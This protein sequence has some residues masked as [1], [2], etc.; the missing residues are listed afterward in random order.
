MVKKLYFPL[1]TLL[2]CLC[3]SGCTG[4]PEATVPPSS[5]TAAVSP[6]LPPESEAPTELPTAPLTAP[7][8]A[9]AGTVVCGLDLGGLSRADAVQALTAAADSYTMSL[10]TADTEVNISAADVALSFDEEAFDAFW[11]ALEA[12]EATANSLFS[13]DTDALELLLSAALEH[14]AQEPMVVYSAAREMFVLRPGSAGLNRDISADAAQAAAALQRLEA[15]C[16]LEGDGQS[17]PPSVSDDDPRLT[18]AADEANRILSTRLVYTFSAEQEQPASEAL[19]RGRIADLVSI[20]PDY[21]VSIH[22]DAV[23]RCAAALSAA[24]SDAVRQGDFV[25]SAGKT[26]SLTVDYYGQQVDNAALAEDLYFCLSSGISGT[27]EAPYAPAAESGLPYGGSYVEVD[28]TRQELL[29][30]RDGECVVSTPIVSGCVADGTR[31]PTGVFTIYSM[32]RDTWLSG[33]T[34][35]DHVDYW[36]AFYGAYGLHDASWRSEFGDEI[37]LHEGSHGCPNL[38]V[39]VAGQVYEN[40]GIGTHVIIHGGLTQAVDLTQEITGT[41]SYE[42]YATDEAFPLDYILKY[43]EAAVTFRSDDPEV[44]SVSPEG[45]VTVRG[46]GSAS[47]TIRAEAFTYHTAAELS[48]LVTVSPQCRPEEHRFGDWAVVTEAGCEVSGSESRVCDACGAEEH[49]EIPAAGHSFGS[50]VQTAAPDCEAV[51]SESRV[52]DTC[53]AE[54]TREIPAT[55]HSFRSGSFFCG[56]GCG[57]SN[58]DLVWPVLRL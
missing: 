27:R 37:Y 35:Y 46:A 16:I 20:S 51:G 13:V 53:G 49:R 48:V 33:P 15:D 28:L 32:V 29:V 44:V 54:E 31:T 6:V 55:G 34:W 17:V 21:R 30:Y 43:P 58:P 7:F 39:E 10:H 36:M 52:C 41:A 23:E 24:H 1:L 8:T 47:I 42:L 9:P 5:P 2:L 40:V 19:S 38:P 25:T 3:L 11:Q 18:E 22:R 45:I 50:W 56:N 26:V 4:S 57:T 14:P 12:G